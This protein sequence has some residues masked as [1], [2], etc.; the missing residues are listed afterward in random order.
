MCLL[1]G[2][3]SGEAR[4]PQP[5]LL[6]Y[7]QNLTDLGM[8][9]IPLQ[10]SLP[11]SMG[12][13]NTEKHLFKARRPRSTARQGPDRRTGAGSSNAHLARH[14]PKGLLEQLLSAGASGPGSQK[15]LQGITK[16]KGTIRRHRATTQTGQSRNVGIIRAGT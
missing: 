7:Y 8:E 3:A 1:R 4:S 2:H 5:H 12:R 16:D 6:G 14:W 10:P 13:A 11:A 9:N 15:N